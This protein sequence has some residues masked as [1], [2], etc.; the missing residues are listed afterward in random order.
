MT[1]KQLE[2]LK[3]QSRYYGIHKDLTPEEKEIHDRISCIDTINSCIA[4]CSR[5]LDCIVRND[6]MQRHVDKLGLDTVTRLAQGQLNDIVGVKYC[7]YTD[8][9]GCSYNSIV[10][11]EDNSND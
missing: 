6:Y 11:K 8:S 10:W 7:V 1:D 3:K 9:E 2:L 5:N 4:Y